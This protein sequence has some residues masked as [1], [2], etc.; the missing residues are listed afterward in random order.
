MSAIK[1]L[2]GLCFGF[3]LAACQ[4]DR[5]R[6]F[7]PGSYVSSAGGEFSM[8]SD[9][10]KVELVEGNNYKVLRSTGYNLIRNGKVGRR[11]YETQ[12][13]SCTYSVATNQL[14]ELRKGRVISFFPGRGEL[15]VGKRI[16]KKIN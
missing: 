12:V 5:V 10:L 1:L 16:Y 3:A 14:T 4:G 8:A 6:D 7:M 9:T 15:S 11:E 2:L 13:W